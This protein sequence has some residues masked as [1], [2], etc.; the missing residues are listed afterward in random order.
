MSR[1]RELASRIRGMFSQNRLDRDLDEE[2]GVHLEMLID[3]NVRRGMSLKEAR[4]AARRSFG[5]VQQTRESYRDQRGLPIVETLIQDIR[6]G[7]EEESRLYR[8]GCVYAR[9]RYRG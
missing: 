3:E 8:R 9:A 7:C 4:D 2:L 5:G 6:F 1:L